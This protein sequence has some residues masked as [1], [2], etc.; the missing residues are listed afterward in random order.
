MRGIR[1]D[2][3]TEEIKKAVKK[4]VGRKKA[5]QLVEA[6]QE[7]IQVWLPGNGA[8]VSRA[9]SRNGRRGYEAF[10]EKG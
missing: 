7:S 10:A 4:T 8:G 2:G 3:V 9:K 5:R 6:A 1:A